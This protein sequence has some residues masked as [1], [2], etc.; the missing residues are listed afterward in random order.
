MPSPKDPTAVVKPGAGK[1][2]A[3]SVPISALT[4]PAGGGSGDLAAH[5]ADPVDAHMAF[6]IGIPEIDPVTGEPL[7]S[8]ADGAY[9]G[10][11]VLDALRMLKELIPPRPDRVGFN[12]TAIPNTGIPSWGDLDAFSVGGVAH[13]GGW[14]DGTTFV[15]SNCIV[16][17]TATAA[18]LTGTVF[19]ADRGVLAIY[20]C[21]DGTFSTGTTSLVAALWLGPSPAPVGIASAAF[22]EATRATSQSNYTATGVGIDKITLTKRLPYKASYSPGEYTAFTKDFPAFQLAT[23]ATSLNVPADK[24]GSYVL[25]HW[26]E[27]YATSL[28]V[29]SS[30][31]TANLTTSNCYSAVPSAGD[32]DNGNIRNISKHNIFRDSLS[33]TPPAGTCVTSAP[34]GSTVA[35][36]GVQHYT[37]DLTFTLQ[38][39]ATNLFNKSYFTGTVSSPPD[40]PANFVG[41]KDPVEIDL[42]DF[43]VTAPVGK[44][45]YELKDS[46]SVFFNSNT[47][48]PLTTDTA[49]YGPSAGFTIPALPALTYATPVGGF[50]IVKANLN[51]SSATTVAADAKKFLYN[52]YPQTGGTTASTDTLEKFVDEQYRVDTLYSPTATDAMPPTGGA[53]Y[54]SA[55]AL[56]IATGPATTP[57]TSLQVIGGR[58]VYPQTDYSVAAFSPTGPNYNAVFLGDAINTRRLYV[59][60]FDTGMPRST[61]RFR[62]KGLTY[63]DF[64]GV[65]ALAANLADHPGK[66]FVSLHIP[67]ATGFLD[68]GRVKG[69][70]DLSLTDQRGCLTAIVSGSPEGDV[71]EYDMTAYTADNG[72]GKFLI[73]LG[74]TF[75][76]DT[77]IA[78]APGAGI[79]ENLY[80]DEIEWL[81]PI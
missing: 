5:L 17:N 81:P 50:A 10:E 58:L 54:N 20:Y 41:D 64:K 14:T 56:A 72:S 44:H 4:F 29:I 45:Y 30:Y 67:G 49:Q 40:V 24:A 74:I 18:A 15:P 2:P 48:V 53:D 31:A 33:A 13:I 12:S 76:K 75:I 62:I 32:Y 52:G 68:L 28:A 36:S 21:T 38:V 8:S 63:N 60:A 73:Y 66:V 11:S 19:P 77:A 39:N 26:R 51:R 27:T 6:A 42:S 35:L 47:N 25:V 7:L 70:P 78:T 43:G 65:G 59:R 3:G 37:T 79:V 61:G 9:D 57:K 16:P 71:F 23:Y 22:N 34:S 55:T 80:V 69:D 46:G 1:V